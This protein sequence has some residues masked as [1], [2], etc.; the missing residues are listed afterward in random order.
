MF[1]SASHTAKGC[2]SYSRGIYRGHIFFGT[3]GEMNQRTTELKSP[4]FRVK[5]A[6]CGGNPVDPRGTNPG[7]LP[8]LLGYFLGYFLTNSSGR[9]DSQ[10]TF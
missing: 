7:K 8:F 3:G 4:K 5:S 10:L 9:R 2:Y 1:A 6:K